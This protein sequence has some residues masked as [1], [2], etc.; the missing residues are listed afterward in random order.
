MKK[1]LLISYEVNQNLSLKILSAILKKKYDITN[2]YLLDHGAFDFFRR[3]KDEPPLKAELIANFC[4]SFDFVMIS[5]NSYYLDV[6]FNILDT[7]KKTSKKTRTILGGPIGLT[8]TKY[9]LEHADAVCIWEGHNIMDIMNYFEGKKPKDNTIANFIVNDPKIK[10]KYFSLDNY[11][12]MPF[13]DYSRK[14]S[15]FYADGKIT[16]NDMFKLD[17][18]NVETMKG[19]VFNCSFCS[20][21][22]YNQIKKRNKLPIVIK[23]SIKNAI[24]RLKQA[25][26]QNKD[27]THFLLQDDNFFFYEVNEIK[28][29][30]DLYN[31][32]VN[33][34][35]NIQLDP[36]SKSFKEKFF[37]LS[38]LKTKVSINIGIQSGSEKFN[39]E[40]Y[41][42]IQ[43]N[44]KIIEYHDYM[45]S[46]VEDKKIS[47]NYFLI[48]ANPFEKKKDV[49]DTINLMLRLKGANFWIHS[50]MN[51]PMTT[52]FDK[53]PDSYDGESLCL[54]P[55]YTSYKKYS[56]Y[57]AL[58]FITNRLNKSKISWILPKKIRSSWFIDIL[59]N[60]I[61]SSVSYRYI[62]Y[63]IKKTQQRFNKML[64]KNVLSKRS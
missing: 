41:D 4:S 31:K 26:D 17:F 58:I 53:I 22:Y 36:R 7:I 35:I 2:L 38:K 8:H 43:N 5:A 50:Y 14:K 63:N 64:R 46:I 19:C 9:C 56:F 30:V 11:D 33:H 61:F 51:I 55:D 16:R 39:K 45:L 18:I 52:L 3:S 20:I 24:D 42:R 60:P 25:K 10:T 27:S 37:E 21:S 57:Y 28:E 47:I 49:L 1:I 62:N 6:T 40:I 48:Y 29:F 13:P 12:D 59:N 34:P 32:E 15:F 23:S 54:Q 44:K